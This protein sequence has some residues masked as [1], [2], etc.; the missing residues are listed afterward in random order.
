M[1]DFAHLLLGY[2][3]YKA[4]LLSGR[5]IGQLELAACLLGSIAPD[6]AWSSGLQ[7]NYAVSHVAT[8]YVLLALPFLLSDRTRMAGVCFA[9][10]STAHVLAD[11]PIHLGTWTPFY[12][13]SI[14]SINGS[15]NYW[16]HWWA[17]AAYWALLLV[18]LAGMLLYE[19]KKTGRILIL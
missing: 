19:K 13:L 8:Y 5:K 6:I 11:A 10:A 1:D 17:M 4:L 14:I 7:P 3:V 12:P 16:E 2:L 9:L 18:A 15:L